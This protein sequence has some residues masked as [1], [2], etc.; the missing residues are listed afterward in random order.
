MSENPSVLFCYSISIF[1]AVLI[2]CFPDAVVHASHPVAAE[3]QRHIGKADL[4][5]LRVDLLIKITGEHLCKIL[6]ADL[7]TGNRIRSALVN[8]HTHLMKSGVQQELLRANHPVG[9]Y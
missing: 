6:C 5:A 7:D 2:L 9:I 3:I 8:P 4:F 1:Y